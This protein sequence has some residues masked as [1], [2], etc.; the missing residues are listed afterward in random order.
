MGVIFSN[1]IGFD[2]IIFLL[3]AVNGV[4]YFF[5][6]K[7]VNEL[8]SKM[9]LTVFVPGRRRSREDA[10]DEL[11]NLRESD[12]VSMRAKM[13]SLYSVFINITGIFPLLGILGTVTSLLGLVN[14]MSDVQGS[15]YAALTSTAWGIIFS[16]VFKG[17]DSFISPKIEENEKDVEL[18]LNRNSVKDSEALSDDMY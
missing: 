18:F 7:S 16:I 9:H 13:G 8:R 5:T 10:R 4:V 2:G 14:D 3:A 17:L 1:I 15:F 6:R 11:A 12:V